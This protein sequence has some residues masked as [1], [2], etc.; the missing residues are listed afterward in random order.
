[1]RSLALISKY[2]QQMT[3]G[4]QKLKD[5]RLKAKKNQFKKVLS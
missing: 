3:A 2:H 1:M 5:N 4:G